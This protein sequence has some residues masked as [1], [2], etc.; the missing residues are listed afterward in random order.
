MSTHYLG[1]NTSSLGLV[2]LVSLLRML[3]TADSMPV[4]MAVVAEVGSGVACLERV[5]GA[6]LLVC[7][8][9]F[10]YGCCCCR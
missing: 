1:S 4:W 10:G 8:G 9:V 7:D 5:V 2:L 6:I 3:G